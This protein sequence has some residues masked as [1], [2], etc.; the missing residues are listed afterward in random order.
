M[1]AP[2][3]RTPSRPASRTGTHWLERRAYLPAAPGAAAGSRGC[4]RILVTSCP[5]PLTIA[6][7]PSPPAATRT[8]CPARRPGRAVGTREPALPGLGWWDG[9]ACRR[10][11]G[12]GLSPTPFW[13]PG[14][15][16]ARL[17][18]GT[19]R[20]PSAA[21][22]PVCPRAAQSESCPGL[23]KEIFINNL[24]NNNTVDLNGHAWEAYRMLRKEAGPG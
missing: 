17:S 10:G 2:P 3:L 24:N 14:L 11:L 13:P 22:H 4:G 20:L 9:S 5:A 8:Q 7:R 18:P 19:R 6:P 1:A 16:A 21:L 15:S 23:K 12:A